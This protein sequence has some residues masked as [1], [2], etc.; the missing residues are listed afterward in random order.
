MSDMLALAAALD[1]HANALREVA[2]AL[3][4]AGPVAGSASAGQAAE[5]PK[6]DK[7][8]R[9][10]RAR[11]QAEAKQPEPEDTVQEPEAEEATALDY[12]A[13]VKPLVQ[14]V[15]KTHGREALLELFSPF[16]AADGKPVDHGTKLQA[17]DYGRFIEAA[18]GLLAGGEEDYG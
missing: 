16:K 9:Q 8:V 1:N 15:G 18:V 7:P 14:A 3:A 12:D 5:Q 2:T 11:Q 13:D 4:N 10:S 17:K 6:A